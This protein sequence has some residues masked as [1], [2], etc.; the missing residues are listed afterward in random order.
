M[1]GYEHGIFT[2][3]AKYCCYFCTSELAKINFRNADEPKDIIWE[4]LRVSDWARFKARAKTAIVGTLLT[5]ICLAII[6]YIN[7]IKVDRIESIIY[8]EDSDELTIE[9]YTKL[10]GYS[11][12]ISIVVCIFNEV[13]RK[14]MM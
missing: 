8:S 10:Q 6:V 4:N 14:V 13:L 1:F 11:A 7:L 12:L 2:L 9:Q 3:L 5:G